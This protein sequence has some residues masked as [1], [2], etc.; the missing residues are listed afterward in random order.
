M[1][2][3]VIYVVIY[4]ISI[5]IFT[6]TEYSMFRNVLE[7]TKHDFV[8]DIYLFFF[9]NNYKSFKNLQR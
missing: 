2:L 5:T 6:E 3:L 1:I 8:G 7:V 9:L 4:I